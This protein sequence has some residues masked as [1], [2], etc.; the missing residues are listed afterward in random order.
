[1]VIH[2]LMHMLIRARGTFRLV[3]GTL[4]YVLR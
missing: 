3:A 2:M 1:M 4:G